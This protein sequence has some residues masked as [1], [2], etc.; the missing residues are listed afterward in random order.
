VSARRAR[1]NSARIHGHVGETR[2]RVLDA[3]R[4]ALDATTRAVD[5][6]APSDP[7]MVVRLER[8]ATRAGRS[9]VIEDAKARLAEKC[10]ISRSDAFR[11]L[12]ALSNSTTA[13]C[14]TSPRRSCGS[15]SPAGCDKPRPA[16]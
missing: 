3:Q 2:A 16:R 7:V 15:D 5:R 11:V 13:R 9:L 4:F 6:D 12:T 8:L 14:A 1:A 10:G